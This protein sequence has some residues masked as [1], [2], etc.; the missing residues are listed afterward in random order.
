MEELKK[1]TLL[2]ANCHREAHIF[3]VIYTSSFDQSIADQYLHEYELP[4]ATKLDWSSIDLLELK[5][6]YGTYRAMARALGVSDT[7]VHKHYKAIMAG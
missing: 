2:C 1:C 3:N 4:S 6:I 7:I 5:Q